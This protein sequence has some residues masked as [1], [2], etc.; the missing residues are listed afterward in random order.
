MTKH[1]VASLTVEVQQL[2]ARVIALEAALAAR[3]TAPAAPAA[4]HSAPR[5]AKHTVQISRRDDGQ[6]QVWLD[7]KPHTTHEKAAAARAEAKQLAM[8]FA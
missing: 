2:H 7:Y 8:S 4:A 6:W 1:T 5:A 3:S